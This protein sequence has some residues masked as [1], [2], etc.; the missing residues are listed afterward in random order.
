[1]TS[2]STQAELSARHLYDPAPRTVNMT[3]LINMVKDGVYAKDK[4]SDYVVGLLI[5]ARLLG[6]I[7]PWEGTLFQ[8]PFMRPMKMRKGPL[9]RNGRPAFGPNGTVWKLE[10]VVLC[11]GSWN[12]HVETLPLTVEN[13]MN[14]PEWVERHLRFDAATYTRVYTCNTLRECDRIAN[15]LPYTPGPGSRPP[16]APFVSNAVVDPVADVEESDGERGL[17]NDGDSET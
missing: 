6:L 17:E 14:H 12:N 8:L 7:K 9:H 1:M 2:Q 3:D 5:A 11:G 16:G 15:F 4:I 13:L 10:G